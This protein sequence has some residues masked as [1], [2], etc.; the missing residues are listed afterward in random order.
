MPTRRRLLVLGC[1]Q[2]FAGCRFVSHVRTFRGRH[3]PF[4]VG[5]LLWLVCRTNCRR[6]FAVFAFDFDFLLTV[7]LFA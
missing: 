2:N 6:F 1:L 7:I 4:Y 5:L 3:P